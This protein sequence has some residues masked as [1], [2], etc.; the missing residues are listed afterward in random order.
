M[1][2]AQACKDYDYMIEK[3][4]AKLDDPFRITTDTQLGRILISDAGIFSRHSYEGKAPRLNLGVDADDYG[5]WNLL[6]APLRRH[7]IGQ[8]EYL[9]KRGRLWAA[10]FVG[11]ALIAPMLIMVLHSTLVTTLVT[12][13][14]ATLLFALLV[15]LGSGWED[16]KVVSAV[17]AYAAVMV[18]FVGTHG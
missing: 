9:A 18:V 1:I 16:D 4:A 13:S 14:V 5:D 6:P 3:A 7:H 15:A 17:A 2:I 11:V 8:R 10:L 12:S